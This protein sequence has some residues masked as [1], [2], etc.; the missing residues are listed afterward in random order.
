MADFP[1]ASYQAEIKVLVSCCPFLRAMGKNQLPNPCQLLAESRFCGCR[2]EVPISL[3]AVSWGFPSGPEA[4]PILLSP[5]VF[6]VT[7][8]CGTLLMV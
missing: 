4:I 7:G 5:S 8:T 2:T 3:L 6:Q 1:A